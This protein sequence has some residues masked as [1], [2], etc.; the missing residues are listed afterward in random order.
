MKTREEKAA[1][2]GAHRKQ[3]PG[4]E[5]RPGSPNTGPSVVCY[6]I[7][8]QEAGKNEDSRTFP[9]RLKPAHLSVT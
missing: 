3:T 4:L 6:Y 7:C 8:G 5:L 2:P 1:C 9:I